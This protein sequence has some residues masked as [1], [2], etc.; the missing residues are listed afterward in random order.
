MGANIT[1]RVETELQ[2]VW[3]LP[4]QDGACVSVSVSVF[5]AQVGVCV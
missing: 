5:P 3:N 4:A 1:I 2:E